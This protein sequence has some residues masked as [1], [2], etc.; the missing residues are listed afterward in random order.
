MLYYAYYNISHYGHGMKKIIIIFHILLCYE[1]IINIF[2]VIFVRNVFL[3]KM[4]DRVPFPSKVIH[5][6]FAPLGK[7]LKQREIYN[8]LHLKIKT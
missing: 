1:S 7:W 3:N 2:F 5:T 8:L 6:A 4:E